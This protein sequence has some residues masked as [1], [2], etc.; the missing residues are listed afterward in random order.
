MLLGNSE[1]ASSGDH[2]ISD[3]Q[4]QAQLPHVLTSTSFSFLGQQYVGK[5]RDNYSKGGVRYLI[6]SDR[7]SCFDVVVTSIPFKGQVLTQMAQHWFSLSE[8]IVPNHIID[9]P[10]PN[11]MV[12][13]ECEMLPVEV[14]VRAY[15]T[16]SAWRDYEAGRAIS[17]ITLPPGLTPSEK[18]PQV[19]ITPSTKAAKGAHD[20]PISEADILGQGLV[21]AQL[22]QQVREVSF[23]LFARGQQEAAKQGLLL[24]DTKYEFGLSRGKLTLVDEIHTLDSSRYWR[25]ASY[26]EAVKHG[27]V[28]EMLDKEPTRQWLLAQGYKGEGKIPAFTDDHRVKIARHY[29]DSYES[30]VG[31]AF[32]AQVG[33]VAER[34][35]K[36]LRQ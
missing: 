19:L 5:V 16:G 27:Q 26:P 34:I 24:V 14:V 4:L 1:L 33:S 8:D 15:L 9:I 3:Q 32:E 23:A 10:D 2:M 31:R 22:W 12:V 30:V 28:P 36:K 7:L 35:E 25:A 18:L 29:I 21:S 17:G 13:N 11:V 20:Q 6:A